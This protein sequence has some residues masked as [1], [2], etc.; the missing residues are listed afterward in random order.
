[1]NRLPHPASHEATETNDADKGAR[2]QHT[3]AAPLGL[4]FAV[5]TDE[6]PGGLM[7]QAEDDFD[8]FASGVVLLDARG[9]IVRLNRAAIA[10]VQANDGLML[11]DDMLRA[12]SPE[13][14]EQ[15]HDLIDGAVQVGTRGGAGGTMQIERPSGQRPW[16]ALVLPLV[17]RRSPQWH[18]DAVAAVFIHES[19]AR[20]P[21]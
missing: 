20:E 12:A 9:R 3:A 4:A 14:T 15:L 13:R 7:T 5:N 10:I 8:R 11:I 19:T 1:M 16:I 2:L 6:P 17:R 18:P 21:E